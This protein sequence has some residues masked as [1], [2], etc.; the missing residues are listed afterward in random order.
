MSNKII[1]GKYAAAV[2]VLCDNNIELAKRRLSGLEPL[3][4]LFSIPEAYK[5]LKSPVMPPDLKLS[6]LNYA[7]SK[8]TA[9]EQLAIFIQTIVE[10]GRVDCI[11]AVITRLR[12]II[13]AAEG[14]LRANL[15]TAQTVGNADLQIISAALEKITKK[16]VLINHKKDPAIL[17]GF[18]VQLENNL[19]DMSLRTKLDALTDSAAV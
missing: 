8:G 11:P 7:L 18:I 9:D 15:I 12:E 14:I 10:A 4:Q 16:S 19:I 3:L 17:G 5:V 2:M 13:D 1:A 6:L